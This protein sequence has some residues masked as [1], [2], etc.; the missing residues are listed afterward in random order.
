MRIGSNPH[1]PWLPAPW[2]ELHTSAEF[3]GV[4]RLHISVLT[5]ARSPRPRRWNRPTAIGRGQGHSATAGYPAR[6][7]KLLDFDGK[8]A[9]M[10]MASCLIT[11]ISPSDTVGHIASYGIP[12]ATIRRSRNR[13]QNSAERRQPRWRLIQYSPLLLVRVV[14]KI[15]KCSW[16]IRR[17]FT[18]SIS[19]YQFFCDPQVPYHGTPFRSRNRMVG[20]LAM[21]HPGWCSSETMLIY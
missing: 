2:P 1:G 12:N 8:S 4:F 18:S 6:S 15:G 3:A 17:S 5:G 16:C 19:I 7:Y 14:R 20:K 10:G 9:R 13:S 11:V 21:G